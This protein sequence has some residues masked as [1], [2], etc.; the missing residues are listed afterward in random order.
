MSIPLAFSSSA[1]SGWT[2]SDT[3]LQVIGRVSLPASPSSCLLFVSHTHAH[4]YASYSSPI[5]AWELPGMLRLF[6][7]FEHLPV[8]PLLLAL[9]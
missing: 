3:Y 5:E 6:S 9:I 4:K 2:N 1:G 7:Y 8:V